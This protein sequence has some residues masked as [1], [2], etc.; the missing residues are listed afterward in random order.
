M[1]LF[2]FGLLFASPAAAITSSIAH[3]MDMNG[4]AYAN[5]GAAYS[6][7]FFIPWLCLL[8]WIALKRRPVPLLGIGTISG[9]CALY[10]AW[11]RLVA[12]YGGSFLSVLQRGVIEV[13]Y[14]V[15][16]KVGI[17]IAVLGAALGGISLNWFLS[18]WKL[19]RAYL[20]RYAHGSHEEPPLKSLVLCEKH[21][22]PFQ[23]LTCWV[24]F[25]PILH[26]LILEL[27]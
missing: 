27:I 20:H 10:L 21:I 19:T 15:E 1:L 11:F 7:L 26:Y 18:A 22:H 24:V 6:T 14:H 16:L 5:A 3:K 2:L 23:H 8:L 13:E 9:Y 12:F 25:T 4:D 17:E